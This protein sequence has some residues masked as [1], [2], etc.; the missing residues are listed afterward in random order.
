MYDEENLDVKM[1]RQLTKSNFETECGKIYSQIAGHIETGAK[2]G[3]SE[4]HV[5]IYADEV[6]LAWLD[7][8]LTD[9][10]FEVE[11][12]QNLE[13]PLQVTY[14]VKWYEDKEAIDG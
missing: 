3:R 8:K 4:C 1:A 14:I 13:N 7:E 9:K 12:D 6:M 2:Y 5:Q 11:W 10:G